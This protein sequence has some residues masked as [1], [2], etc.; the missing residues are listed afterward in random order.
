MR[1]KLVYNLYILHI[2]KFL[3]ASIKTKYYIFLKLYIRPD[4]QIKLIG[5][6]EGVCKMSTLPRTVLIRN[7]SKSKLRREGGKAKILLT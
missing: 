7:S 6:D 4:P 3:V 5:Q 1:L 2:L